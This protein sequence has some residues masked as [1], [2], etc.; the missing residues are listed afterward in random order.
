MTHFKNADSFCIS[1]KLCKD[2]SMAGSRHT[3]NSK[4]LFHRENKQ[5]E[6]TLKAIQGCPSSATGIKDYMGLGS[7][8]NS[9]DTSPIHF[10]IIWKGTENCL[11]QAMESFIFSMEECWKQLEFLTFF[12]VSSGQDSVLQSVWLKFINSPLQIFIGRLQSPAL[13]S[14]SFVIWLSAFW[15]HHNRGRNPSRTY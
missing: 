9:K 7:L 11:C 6:E 15:S 4:G 5:R 14:F 2:A 8:R 3:L 1:T 10:I 13:F 12:T